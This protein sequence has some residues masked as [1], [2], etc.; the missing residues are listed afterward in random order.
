[1]VHV[2][3]S[4]AF[5]LVAVAGLGLIALM[6]LQEQD[7]IMTA[8]GLSVEPTRRT[9]HRPVRVRTAG[10]WQAASAMAA[11]PWRAAA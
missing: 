2:L 7:K 5:T 8:L 6:L 3:A 11:R 9:A 4:L 1:M 10:R